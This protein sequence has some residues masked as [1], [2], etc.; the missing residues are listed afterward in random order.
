MQSFRVFCLGTILSLNVSACLADGLV[1]NQVMWG[2]DKRAP[3]RVGDRTVCTLM[4][5]EWPTTIE[6]ENGDW[7][8]IGDNK[9][10][11][12]VKRSA[13]VSIDEFVRRAT[14]QLA[15]RPTAL[16]YSERGSAWYA[17]GEYDRAIKDH[18]EALRLERSVQHKGVKYRNR[19]QAYLAIG[20]T[21]AAINDF[22]EAIRLIHDRPTC[23]YE[24]YN[25]RAVAYERLGKDELA[26]ADRQ[27][28]ERIKQSL[29]K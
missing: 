6:N 15:K 25:A 19:G 2:T 21:E 22:S 12:W 16:A 28:A 26:G 9:Y 3:V 11:G 20:D 7:V 18:T 29:P 4:E 10:K 24:C 13:V 1:G 27:E 8:F 23:L 14:A 5:I 17:M